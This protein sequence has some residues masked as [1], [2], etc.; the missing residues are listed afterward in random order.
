MYNVLKWCAIDDRNLIDPLGA[1]QK[2][3][4]QC[5]EIMFKHFVHTDEMYGLTIKSMNYV[6]AK[7]E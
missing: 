4:K 2:I 1:S 5:F 3:T 7:L 6:I